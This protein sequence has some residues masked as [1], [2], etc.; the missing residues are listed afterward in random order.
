MSELQCNVVVVGLGGAGSMAAI[1][2]AEN[3][4]KVI[5]VERSDD[6]GGSTRDSGGNIRTFNDTE[7]AI[8][9]YEYLSYGS[10]PREV[11]RA[12][13]ESAKTLPAWVEAH[14]GKQ[15]FHDP[16]G[17]TGKEPYPQVICPIG[18]M[19]S[20]FEGAPGAEGLATRFQAV[21]EA[22]E[23]ETGF[24]PSG[25]TL[26]QVLVPVMEKLDIE[27]HYNVR[28]DE[29]IV[30]ADGRVAGVTGV[31]PDGTVDIR[32]DRG[33]ILTCGGFSDD[34]K[35]KIDN[36]GA[37]IPTMCGPGKKTGEGVRMAQS[38]GADLFH[39]KD[40]ASV[41]AYKFPDNPAGFFGTMR[42]PGFVLVDQDGLR[43]C[44]ET[45]L[46]THA[47]GL[48][49]LVPDQHR[50]SYRRLPGF[51]VF[52]EETRYDGP[53][54]RVPSGY[55][56][57]FD[58]SIDNSREI[59]RGWITKADSIEELAEKLGLPPEALAKTVEK[60]NG[61]A[62]NGD[63]DHFGRPAE[64]RRPLASAPFYGVP[65]WPALLNTQG[66]PRRDAECRVVDPMGKP[67]PGLFSAGELGSMFAAYYPGGGNVTE[68]LATGLIAGR[69]AATA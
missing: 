37:D 56:A 12:M 5:V 26:W 55:N 24:R 29:L 27:I 69:V 67:I 2:A 63:E 3:G 25:T 48:T 43:F 53:I 60:F 46:E 17:V 21:P 44:N 7:Q 40:L 9:H 47:A 42:G 68:A 49:M 39:M 59:E 16:R 64:L 61:A 18:Y 22:W 19:G 11:I 62:A 8:D 15:E 28:I 14:G 10:T 52:D 34:T 33:V 58:W 41:L 4:A 23:A 51:F 66:G 45:E 31:G 54:V 57:G 65:V 35:L 1:E 36:F 30:D 20:A 13:V 6:G 32:A 50:G 38:V